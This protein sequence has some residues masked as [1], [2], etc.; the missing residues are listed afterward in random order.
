LLLGSAMAMGGNWIRRGTV[1]LAGIAACAGLACLT[2]FFLV[3]SVP[4]PGDI[5]SALG[6]H[7]SAYT[8]S[9]GHMM[10]LTFDSFAYLRFPLVI[11]AIALIGGA[12]G[13]VLSKGPRAFLVTA[14]MMALFFHAARLAMVVFDPFLSSRPLAEAL[15]KSPEGKLIVDRH[16]WYF[17]SLTF[18]SNRDA[19]ILNGR[20]FNLEYGSYA[21]GAPDVFIDDTRFKNLWLAPERCYL[22]AY[23]AKIQQFEALVGGEH[24]QIVASGGGKVLLTN[25]PADGTRPPGGDTDLSASTKIT[26][27]MRRADG[28]KF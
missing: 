19:L 17:S 22:M 18:Y 4:A 20:Y 24:L 15:L 6:H 14:L 8:L 10:D 1:A 21:P 3:R 26:L 11:A 16:Y 7:P 13:I 12:M 28:R 5:S 2:I 9:L 27:A 23:Q 25:H